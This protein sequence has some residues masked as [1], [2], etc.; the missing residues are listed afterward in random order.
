[1][2]ET[3]LEQ[4]TVLQEI[5]HA[6][7]HTAVYGF[8]SVL[9]KAFGFFM[10]PF[11]THYLTPADYGILEILDLS[12]SL[13]GMCLNMGIG[14][15]LMRYYAAAESAGSK[16]E[17]IS[18]SFLFVV[19]SGGLIFMAALATLGPASRFLF[20]PKVPSTYL[21]ISVSSFILAYIS[22]VPR[23]YLR[24]LQASRAVVMV[25]T[26]SVFCMLVLNIYFIGVLKIGLR[27]ILFS[28]LLV[29]AVQVLVLSV[30][31]LRTVGVSFSGVL[32]QKMMRFGAPLVLSN[33]AA[34][35]LN[36]SDR[37]FLQQTRS[38]AVVGIYA[39]GYKFGFMLN[40]LLMQPF[41][42][43]WEPRRYVIYENAG[44]PAVFGQVFMLYSLVLTY[45]W[46]ALA[47]LSPEVVRVLVSAE[48]S[49]AQ[50]VIP[51]VAMAYVAW[52]IGYHSQLGMLLKNRTRMVGGISAGAVVLNLALNYVLILHFGMLGAAWA[53]LLS[54]AGIAVASYVFSQRV[55]RLPLGGGRVLVAISVAIGLYLVSRWTNDLPIL[56]TLLSKGVLLAAFPVLVWKSKLLSQAEMATIVSTSNGVVTRLL[57][58]LHIPS[59]KALKS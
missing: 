38:L 8:G 48:F 22:M 4:G 33:L 49:S 7:R 37:F 32:L 15:A 19:T 16:K 53:T 51:I 1:L 50:Y 20:G 11:Y 56:F 34:F 26:V 55:L 6:V 54:F 14:A 43:M 23:I 27:G 59:G 9:V 5:R 13:I 44:Y 30:W 21:L 46:L 31:L 17:V 40:Y 42:A 3:I 25:D 28:A 24:A 10:L 41:C 36:F 45:A 52:G 12:M 29:T 35:T 57:E 39:V 2:A 58:M 47:V 18:T